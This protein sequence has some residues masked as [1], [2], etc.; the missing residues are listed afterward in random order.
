[1]AEQTRYC[2][3]ANLWW[4]YFLIERLFQKLYFLKTPAFFKVV[5]RFRKSYFSRIC[6]FLEQLVFSTVNFGSKVILSIYHLI[7]S[8]INKDVFRPNLPRGAESGCTFRKVF[9]L[10]PWAQILHRIYF[11]RAVWNIL[12]AEKYKKSEF[13]ACLIKI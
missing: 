7:I 1:M 5:I 12:C 11:L 10:I 6:C 4:S 9:L 3:T 8:H 2:G 13:L